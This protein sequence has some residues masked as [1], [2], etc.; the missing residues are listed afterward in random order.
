MGVF[1]M[2]IKTTHKMATSLIIIS[3][4]MALPNISYSKEVKNEDFLSKLLSS[5]TSKNETPKTTQIFEADIK[6][7]KLTS[8]EDF[9]FSIKDVLKNYFDIKTVNKIID[10]ISSEDDKTIQAK[11]V[12]EF[13]KLLPKSPSDKV[14][15]AALIRLANQ[16]STDLKTIYEIKR[17]IAF[18]FV[19]SQGITLILNDKAERLKITEVKKEE[20]L[21]TKEASSSNMP[22]II[23]GIAGLGALGAGGGG[24]SSGT[25]SSTTFLDE[26]STFTENTTLT[27]T[28]SA[29]QEYNNVA[30]YLATST[31]N[32]YT[33]VGIDHA[34]GRGLSGSGKTIAIM[35]NGYR[36]NQ[37][38]L[39]GKTITS[40]NSASVNQHGTHVASTAAGSY[41]SNS[42]T[43]VTDNSSDDYSGGSY[44][45][46]NYGTMGVAYNSDLHLTDY[47]IDVTTMGL[48]TTSAKN[49][50][51][52]VQNNSWGWG[53]C[54]SGNC[55]QTID[56]WVTYQNNNGTT[57]AQ[58]LDVLTDTEAGWTAYLSALD[59][60]QSSGIVVVSAGNDTSSTEVNVQAGLPQIAT[61]LKEAWLVVGNIDTSGS[62]I[63]SSTVTRKGNQCGVVA[64]YCIQA[65]GTN[66]MAGDDD[67]N[68]DY[69]SLSGTSMA[70]PIVSG[71]VALLSEAFP[72]HT[73]SQLADRLLASANN[74]FFTATGTT[75]F[76]NG[77]THGYNS[78]FGH[79]ILDLNA[80]LSPIQTSS[81]LV[82]QT[83]SN[84]SSSNFNHIGDAIRVPL[85]S[86]KIN[87]P[88]AF[89]DSLQNALKGK[90][91]YYY[92]SLNGGFAF[93]ISSL[94]SSEN[95]NSNL[96]NPI[97]FNKAHNI[98]N[99]TNF[100]NSSNFLTVSDENKNLSQSQLMAFMPSG[101]NSQ[102]YIG[103]NINIQNSLSFS[104][105]KEDKFNG[106]NKDNPFKIP[107]LNSSENGE[108][109]GSIYTLDETS[110]LSFGL[111]DGTSFTNQIDTKGFV[112]EY[113]KE[114]GSSK[115]GLFSGNINEKNGLLESSIEGAFAINSSTNTTFI[116]STAYGWLNDEW[117]YNALYTSGFSN[118]KIQ[119]YG[120]IENINN[121]VSSAFS[122]DVS[123][124]LGLTN[125]DSIHF[126]I[127][128]PM[129]IESGN[130][131]MLV[132][133]LYSYDGTLNYSSN[134]IKISPS[135]RQID[136][137]IGYKGNIS[138][139]IDLNLQFALS[140]DAG[141]IK[142]DKINHSTF[143]VGK[144]E[145]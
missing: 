12:E 37:I 86:T 25:S 112:I 128:Q 47:N 92:D 142:S 132:P 60:F 52:I 104:Q 3:S 122:F 83:Q 4:L 140:D 11:N 15:G 76:L 48:A 38:E 80:A 110:K 127:S 6:S 120:L 102:N 63:S 108:S 41:N 31:I 73:P 115:I 126:G 91:A 130:M 78:E 98:I 90:V 138:D 87:L 106:I 64:E 43:F 103:T 49:A 143:L 13:L 24:S 30:Q 118:Y 36:T 23:G 145:F 61:E 119:N 121:T 93:D 39:S 105:R 59:S 10:N 133:E 58:T 9:E 125:N 57:D 65:D 22:I 33:L 74:D 1:I 97:N 70:A 35:D 68:G 5:F 18:Q 69:A 137:I 129:R 135:G 26:S 100:V 19:Q 8:I 144:Y 79:G 141:H 139:V 27:A 123:K 136:F 44:P 94:I 99:K 7:I 32:P 66:I 2:I 81:V 20:E 34:Y 131:S 55:P 109:I 95:K 134:N 111:F 67:S 89:G 107:Y 21:D 45:L 88:A 50:S 14:N 124:P 82:S 46:L 116:G 77:I 101:R 72:N 96:Y 16:L 56:V 62:T 114:I 85:A 17:N 29:R 51:A 75:T 117:S 28:W 42:S 40:Y 54:Q 53:T 84:S 71:S 113:S